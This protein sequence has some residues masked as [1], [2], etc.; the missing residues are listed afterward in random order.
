MKENRRHR[1][2]LFCFYLFCFTN[3]FIYI[4]L[5]FF[6]RSMEPYRRETGQKRSRVLKDTVVDGNIRSDHDMYIE[7]KVRGDIH[8]QA[9]L[10]LASNAEI[11]GNVWCEN[12]V[13]TGTIGGNAE[14][15][16][17]ACLGAKAVIK[18]YLKTSTLSTYSS[19]VIEK[20]MRL[21]DKTNR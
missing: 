20:G 18:G 16:Q 6:N 11:A 15:A 1:K 14:V 12:L 13:T 3:N 17:K 19:A 10:T 4:R 7:G 8:C 21:Q 9:V 5:R 2:S